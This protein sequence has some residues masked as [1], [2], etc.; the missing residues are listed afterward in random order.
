[1]SF[2]GKTAAL[3]KQRPLPIPRILRWRTKEKS[4]LVDSFRNV[5]ER[6]YSY[7]ICCCFYLFDVV[8]PFLYPNDAEKSK[9]YIK[10]LVNYDNDVPDLNIVV[11]K[12]KIGDTH[13]FRV[14]TKLA[15]GSGHEDQ[16]KDQDL[17]GRAKET[18]GHCGCGPSVI[19]NLLTSIKDELVDIRKSLETKPRRRSKCVSSSVRSSRKRIRKALQFVNAMKTKVN[20]FDGSPLSHLDHVDDAHDGHSSH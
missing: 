11:L 3:S 19:S 18:C 10:N 1:M 20:A 5:S 13:Q 7:L 4:E 2:V 6:A 8:R 15:F 16:V 12:K 9:K 17:E 14:K